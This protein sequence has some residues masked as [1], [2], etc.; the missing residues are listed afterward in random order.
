MKSSKTSASSIVVLFGGGG[1]ILGACAFGLVE[2]MFYTTKPFA[3]LNDWHFL[4]FFVL[5]TASFASIP[6]AAG[7]SNRRR[8]TLSVIAWVS[9]A[10][11]TAI[12]VA[13]ATATIHHRMLNIPDWLIPVGLWL[14]PVVPG[15]MTVLQAK[16][17]VK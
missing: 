14:V 1:S 8:L 12:L 13:I 4:V 11:L 7:R 17:L 2:K 16:W 5:F 9:A 3:F 15:I 10:I 6:I